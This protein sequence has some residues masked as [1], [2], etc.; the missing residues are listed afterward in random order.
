MI[1]VD[2]NKPS[3]LEP[4]PGRP[5]LLSRFGWGQPDARRNPSFWI[6]WLV[7]GP[8]VLR[9]TLEAAAQAREV[10]DLGCGS[11]WLALEIARR[12]P[13][14]TVWAVD[15]DPVRL[16]WG[17][18]WYRSL[19]HPDRPQLGTVQYQCV[20]VEQFALE[21]RSLDMVILFFSL[22]AFADPSDTLVRV[23]Q[24]LR[25]GGFLAYYEPTAPPQLNLDRLARVRYRLARWRGQMADLW[26]QRRSLEAR[27]LA[28]A[29]R[30]FRS[31]EAPPEEHL[32]H[33]IEEQLEVLC[34]LRTRSFIDLQ[35]DDISSRR[36][37]L[38]VPLLKGLDELLVTSGTLEGA[39]RFVLARKPS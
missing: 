28:D 23:C 24:A 8:T 21:A 33:R 12:I 30:R 29:V 32:F 3:F 20:P 36:A 14:S 25:P 18:D 7:Y 13:Q 34:H 17:R 6:R 35:L 19:Q 37:P 5:G 15:R 4:V 27:Y 9:R 11:G 16:H 10:A 26:N 38:S 39:C 1:R 31:P 22:S 2:P